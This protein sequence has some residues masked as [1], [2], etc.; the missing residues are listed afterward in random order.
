VH[1]EYSGEI[2]INQIAAQILYHAPKLK[3]LKF[4]DDLLSK[5]VD[6]W[7]Q[8][9]EEKEARDIIDLAR[10]LCLSKNDMNALD[11]SPSRDH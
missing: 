4:Q 3:E 9:K 8:L 7:K 2:P 10:A 6:A 5:V 1:K 11:W